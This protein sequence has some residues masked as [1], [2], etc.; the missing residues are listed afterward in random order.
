M[1]AIVLAALY[2]NAVLCT[3]YVEPIRPEIATKT[4]A[5]E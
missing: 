5:R 2:D 1:A 4:A 3:Y